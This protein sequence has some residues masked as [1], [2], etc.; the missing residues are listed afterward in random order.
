MTT[1][2]SALR[3]MPLLCRA[4]LGILLPP[5]KPHNPRRCIAK[6]HECKRGSNKSANGLIR[7]YLP[8]GASMALLSQQ[9]CNAIARKLNLRPR[10]RLGFRTPLECFNE[11]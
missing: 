9:R 2:M 3:R 5:D 7:Q 4:A 11:S 1:F 6:N 10:K 8:K